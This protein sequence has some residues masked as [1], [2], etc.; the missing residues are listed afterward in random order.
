MVINPDKLAKTMINVLYKSFM[1][2]RDYCQ[3][4]MIKWAKVPLIKVVERSTQINFDISFN[5]F[6]GLKQ[7]AATQSSLEI[8]PE[9]KYL[10]LV[11]KAVLKQRDLNEPINGGVGSFLLF[12]LV[13]TFVR[14]IKKDFIATD[15]REELKE[16]LLSEMLLKFFKFY[17]ED[18]DITKKCIVMTDGG[19]IINKETEDKFLTVISPHDPTRNV[20]KAAVRFNQV[21]DYFSACL[22]FLESHEFSE[23]E[24]FLKYIVDPR[25]VKKWKE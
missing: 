10:I 23:G 20:G 15:K 13:L 25:I 4:Q 8:Y 6:D 7:I 12:C 24:S 22:K 21:I 5:A 14:E 3:I 16:M 18:F 17:A 2:D 19:K 9:M 1:K 11:L